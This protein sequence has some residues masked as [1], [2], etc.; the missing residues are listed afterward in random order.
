LPERLSGKEEQDV[1]KTRIV[2]TGLAVLVAIVAVL[3]L[4]KMSNPPTNAQS[5]PVL[6]EFA[7]IPLTLSSFFDIGDAAPAKECYFAGSSTS[8]ELDYAND[9]WS[10]A[11]T[12]GDGDEGGAH[13]ISAPIPSPG[14]LG[15][16]RDFADQD[17]YHD[18]LYVSPYQRHRVTVNPPSGMYIFVYWMDGWY[19]YILDS[20]YS[21]QP[22]EAVS[23]EYNILYPDH[24]IVVL[25]YPLRSSHFPPGVDPS[26]WHNWSASPYFIQFEVVQ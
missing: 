1:K 13:W 12:L 21:T 20:A 16:D 9:N 4:G 5:E 19:G 11:C 15:P 26:T 7:Y 23:L 6:D 3:A 22:G 2:L 14:Y 8:V 24:A 10:T 18:A 17:F 25:G